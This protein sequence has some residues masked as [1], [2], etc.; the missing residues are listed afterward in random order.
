MADASVDVTGEVRRLR[1]EIADDIAALSPGQWDLP[2][3]CT[4][5][6][7]R[8]VLGHLV[9]MAE[10][11]QV[12]LSW[13]I[14][15]NGV[16]PD[17]ALERIARKLGDQPVPELAARLRSAADRHSRVPGAPSALGLGDLLVHSADALRPT[18]TIPDPPVADVLVVLDAYGKWGRRVVHAAPD[19][20]VSLAAT[21]AEWHR[22]SGPEVR[23]KAVDLLLFVAN[24]QQ[25]VERLEGPGV[26]RLN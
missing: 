20:G 23:G 18:G 6:R 21:D 25:V 13:Q 26:A 4:G 7:V 22:G 9:H 19:R 12:S 8:D 1:L 2:S 3:W 5:W 15:R 16:R 10:S 24:R 11:T 17:V 14:M